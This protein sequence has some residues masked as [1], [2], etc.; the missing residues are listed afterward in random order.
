MKRLLPTCFLPLAVTFTLHAE[1]PVILEK[2][3][4]ITVHSMGKN[5][6]VVID[7]L[8]LNESFYEVTGSV[9]K[10]EI[11]QTGENN[12]V[13]INTGG[14]APNNK[15]QVTNNLQKAK[16][17]SQTNSKTQTTKSQQAAKNAKPETCNVQRVTIKQTGKNNSVKINSR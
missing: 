10:G 9:V 16:S 12:S 14:E 5:N 3:D 17:K 2:P 7:S 13:E 11:T 15:T 6:T 8:Q 1:T 4:T